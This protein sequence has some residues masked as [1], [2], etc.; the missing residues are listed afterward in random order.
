MLAGRGVIRGAW[1][2]GPN[3]R[4]V[5]Q[6]PPIAQPGLKEP[7]EGCPAPAFH[8]R[9]GERMHRTIPVPE[10]SFAPSE[11]FPGRPFAPVGSARRH[12]PR[13]CVP[14]LALLL[15]LLPARTAFAQGDASNIVLTVNGSE[16]RQMS[17]KKTIK[18][19]DISDPRFVAVRGAPADT[20]TV[21]IV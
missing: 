9:R 15:A 11:Q 1:Q 12:C 5:F 17:T 16:P 3:L 19:V 6:A 10:S 4:S 18:T 14:G 21:F 20:T 13:W 8:F 7:S 2:Q